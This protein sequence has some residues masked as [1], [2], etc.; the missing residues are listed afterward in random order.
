MEASD[1][2][3]PNSTQDDA[4]RSIQK[5]QRLD[6]DRLLERLEQVHIV[7]LTVNYRL[8]KSSVVIPALLVRFL[9][10][11]VLFRL[12]S[13]K[14][15]RL[16]LVQEFLPESARRW[17]GV[18]GLD[19]LAERAAV[20]WIPPRLFADTLT[21]QV[22]ECL[23]DCGMPRPIPLIRQVLRD[24]LLHDAKPCRGGLV[25]D[26]RFWRKF[27]ARSL[28]ACSVEVAEECRQRVEFV[29]GQV[30]LSEKIE[31]RWLDVPE[32][33][34][35]D[36][37]KLEAARV[38]EPCER[39]QALEEAFDQGYFDFVA[40]LLA[41]SYS[42]CGRRAHHPLLLWKIWMAMLAV[43]SPKPGI[44]LE[45]VDDSLQLRLFLEVM[46]HEQLP[47]ERRIKGFATERLTPVIE[48]LVLWHQFLLL[49]D[50][51]IE[52]TP[53]FGTDSADMHALARMKTDAAAKFVSPLLGWVIDE[54]RRFCQRA[55]RQILSEHEQAVLFD[56]FEKL[57]WKSL[58]NFGRNRHLMLAAIRDTLGGQLVTPNPY[59]IRPDSSPRDGPVSADIA[60]FAEDL[61]AEFLD[62]MKVFGEKF[63]SSTYYDPEGSPHTKRG[64]TI[65][66]YGVQFLADLKFGLIWSFAVYPAGEGFR[67]AIIDWVIQAKQTFGWDRMVLTSDREY[68]IA[69][70][71][72][73]WQE[74]DIFHYGPR[75]D[76]DR[77]KK[78][79]FV[80][81]DFEIQ[82]GYAVCPNGKRL[83]RKP[84]VFVRGSS[85][86]WRYKAK[87]IDCGNCPLR[88]QCTTGKGS[89]MLC[90]NV[91]REDLA[92]QAERMMADPQRTR[93]LMGR[94][95]AMSEGIVNNLMNHL[96][97]RHAKWKGLALARV[98]VGLAVVMLNTLK[99]HKILHDRL[100]PMTLKPAA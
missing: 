96:G 50:D 43:E 74:E 23:T 29:L 62:R 77:K 60:T 28:R 94:H 84:N 53:E 45:E 71:I 86:Q 51:R 5:Q 80:E 67:P 58:G 97:V 55:G 24:L 30:E 31:R 35:E 11:A 37:A 38:A 17:L 22:V 36:R 6:A 88:S 76:V 83:K 16:A 75:S 41:C 99:W 4:A 100:Q 26:G 79:I 52:I 66:G 82:D 64:K 27:V 69:K 98:Q 49:Q 40:K 72:H 59:R 21:W 42:C 56:A 14:K 81:E 2:I 18:A 8:E 65:H 91:Y 13:P 73:Q 3:M 70:A 85:E 57:D 12:N 19:D 10:L 48:Y 78:G 63:N 25:L 95:R 92:I 61:A 15:W 90:V 32:L 87:G 93:D 44:F 68:T 54:C 89:K 9:T 7:D 46:S 34:E 1:V 20:D 33:R 47:S 39:L